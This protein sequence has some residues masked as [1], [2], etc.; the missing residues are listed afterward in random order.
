MAAPEVVAVM[1]ALTLSGQEPRFVGGC[2][3]DALANR[4]VHDIDIATPLLPDQVIEQLKAAKI[5]FVPT[6]LVHG[7]VTAISD[8]RPFE[9]TTLRID[10]ETDGRHA[11][12]AYTDDWRADAARRDF[13]INALS[14]TTDGDIFDYFGGI[15]DLRLGRV[16]FVGDPEQRITEDVLRILRFFRFYAH[17]GKGD[18]DAKALEACAR[19]A[20]LLK[21]LSAERVGAEVMKLLDAPDPLPAWT[22]LRAAGLTDHF[23]PRATDLKTLQRLLDLEK[24]FETQSVPLRRLA[25]LLEQGSTSLNEVAETLRL[26]NAQTKLLTQMFENAAGVNLEISDLSLRRALYL[27]GGDLVRHCLL[28]AAAR[29]GEMGRLQ[30]LYAQSLSFRPPQFMVTGRDVLE[31][32]CPPGPRV[33]AVLADLE[34]WWIAEDFRPGRTRLLARL[35]EMCE[36]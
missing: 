32:G 33:G 28:L 1:Q 30:D 14:C 34:E 3:R 16:V 5:S 7:T 29:A 2:V 15:A 19:Y 24:I 13:T 27:Y 25:A 17:F 9:I 35:K 18:P 26:S 23:L 6:G 10:V 36:N 22:A 8:G 4:L 12:V 31:T 11:H 21:N 20:P